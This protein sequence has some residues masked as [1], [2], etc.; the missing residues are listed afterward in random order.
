[1]L[2]VGEPSTGDIEAHFT[3]LILKSVDRKV[4]LILLVSVFLL[5]FR[6]L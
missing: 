2:R 5:G 3:R 4:L 1:M 6:T